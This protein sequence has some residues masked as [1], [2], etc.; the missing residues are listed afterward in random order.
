MVD[1]TCE[2]SESAVVDLTN[3]DSVLVTNNIHTD[4]HTYTHRTKRLLLC[5]QTNIF[6][7]Y[8]VCSAAAFVGGDD[9]PA[10]G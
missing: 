6:F 8:I 4:A 1:L 9:D 5:H 3:N 7:C 10:G 2:G